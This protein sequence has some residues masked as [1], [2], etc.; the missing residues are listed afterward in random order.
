[1]HE[2]AEEALYREAREETGLRLANCRY[3]FSAPNVYPYMGFDVHTLDLFFE[4]KVDSFDV[5][6]ASDDAA[7][8]VVCPPS[9]LDPAGFGL[10]SIRQAVRIYSLLAGA[11]L[12]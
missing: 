6:K 11:G 7:A 8:L 9:G 3:L 2:T 5:A 4:C 1:M 10:Q 12:E